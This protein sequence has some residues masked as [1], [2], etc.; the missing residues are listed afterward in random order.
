MR[1][2]QA[3]DVV[4]LTGLTQPQLREWTERRKLL[5][6]SVPADGPGTRA[7][8]SW[9]EIITIRIAAEMRATFG[10]QLEQNRRILS[11]IKDTIASHA[12]P[13]LWGTYLEIQPREGVRII[14]RVENLR[15]SAGV[16]V[17]PLDPHL[18]VLA[19]QV[20]DSDIDFQLP[21][22]RALGV[23]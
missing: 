9:V 12:F 4:R 14:D 6:P 13:A 2:F 16:L 22:F 15:A 5:T 7:L 10:M 3:R 8:F 18:E 23:K 1:Y 19:S 17:L 21:L 11:E 20:E